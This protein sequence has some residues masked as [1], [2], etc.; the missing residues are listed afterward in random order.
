[1]YVST[2]MCLAPFG[3]AGLSRYPT[4][5]VWRITVCFCIKHGDPRVCALPSLPHPARHTW[6]K[7]ND[8][9]TRGG[10]GAAGHSKS[11]DF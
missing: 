10:A 11:I 5:S 8:F 6:L 2:D 3:S 7:T 4:R 9:Q 1:M